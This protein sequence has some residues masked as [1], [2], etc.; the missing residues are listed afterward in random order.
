MTSRGELRETVLLYR[1]I[2]QC[3]VAVGFEVANAAKQWRRV[4]AA[5]KR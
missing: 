5:R 4:V 2:P 3:Y 1:N